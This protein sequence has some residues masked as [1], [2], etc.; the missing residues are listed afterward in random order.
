[1]AQAQFTRESETG[2]DFVTAAMEPARVVPFG[3]DT[4]GRLTPHSRG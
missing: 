4:A 1:M 3:P 2:G